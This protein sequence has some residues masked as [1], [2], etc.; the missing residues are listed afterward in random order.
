M[1]RKFMFFG[2]Y[3]TTPNAAELRLRLLP[4]HQADIKS[5]PQIIKFGGPFFTDEGAGED[6]A[7][8]AYGGTFFL[9]EAESY[10]AAR[11]IIES[12]LYYKDGL[13]DVKNIK[14]VE[15][16]PLLGYPF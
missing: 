1:A 16:T 15:Y 11:E 4:Q 13:W 2:P 10:A 9:M 8:R 7:E 12:D 14:L 6:A 5:R 3:I